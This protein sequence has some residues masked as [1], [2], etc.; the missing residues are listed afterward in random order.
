MQTKANDHANRI[1]EFESQLFT[2]FVIECSET[3][4]TLLFRSIQSTYR[5]DSSVHDLL[6]QRKTRHLLLDLTGMIMPAMQASEYIDF[7]QHI[8]DHAAVVQ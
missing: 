2:N 3:G 1:A 4:R 5:T 7:V 8:R 6:N